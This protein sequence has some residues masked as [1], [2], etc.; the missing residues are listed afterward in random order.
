MKLS[1]CD[2]FRNEITYVAHRVLKNGVCP[3]SSNLEAIA[4]CAPPWS[5]TE[6]CTFL[7]LVGHYRRFIKGFAC[8]TQPLSEYL[9]REGASKK[10]EWVSLTEE[11][12]KAFETLKQVCM[13]APS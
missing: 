6:V 5:Y 4:K 3:S 10:S 12:M 2:Y 13:T 7:G 1:K 9:A 8:I 11:A